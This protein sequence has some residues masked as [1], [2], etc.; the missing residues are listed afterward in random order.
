MGTRTEL[1]GV[2]NSSSPSKSGD[3]GAVDR[4]TRKGEK[5]TLDDSTIAGIYER[6]T[7]DCVVEAATAI[8][9]DYRARYRQY[10]DVDPK[11][12]IHLADIKSRVGFDPKWP[13]RDQRTAIN[14]PLLGPS[15]AEPGADALT[16]FCE[17]AKAIRAAAISYSERVFDT[18]EPMLRQAFIDAAR[19]F[20]AYLKTLSGSVVLRAQEDIEPFFRRSSEV[21]SDKD[22][23]HAFGLPPAPKGWPL[24]DKLEDRSSD[25]LDGD[26][27]YLVDEVSRVLQEGKGITQQQFLSLQRAATSGARTIH[28]VLQKDHE[29]IRNVLV[30][31]EDDGSD[32]PHPKVL[33][34]IGDAYSWATA[35]RDWE[36]TLP[37]SQSESS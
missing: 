24:P 25:Y 8:A 29:L 10:R 16:P 6:W 32:K 27:A 7:L 3:E 22:V 23:A 34:L 5:E 20:Y 2:K 37:K 4:E 9:R 19:H 31:N 14:A 21:L 1:P 15:D 28:F 18:G 12:A 36:A 17:V 26:G 13:N 33:R 11:V 30:R 35:L